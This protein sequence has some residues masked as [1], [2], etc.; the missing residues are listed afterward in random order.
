VVIS[1]EKFISFYEIA[2]QARNDIRLMRLPRF[3]PID[4]R[5]W[6]RGQIQ[7]LWKWGYENGDSPQFWHENQDRP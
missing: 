1:Y 7:I 3:A 5:N 4:T 2:T 6:K